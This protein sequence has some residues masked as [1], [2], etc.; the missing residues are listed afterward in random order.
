MPLHVNSGSPE[1]THRCGCFCLGPL[2][3]HGS[4]VGAHLSLGRGRT[5]AHRKECTFNNGLAFSSR[6]V[7]VGEEVSLQVK[8]R[9]GLWSGSLRLG[10]TNVPPGSRRLPPPP[11]AIPH[12]TD[13]AGHWAN[14]VPETFCYPGSVVTFW[15]SHGGTVYCRVRNCKRHK[16]VEAV[17]LS[18]PLWAMLDVYGQTC[19]VLLLGSEKKHVLW[20]RTSC[21]PPSSYGYKQPQHAGL[22]DSIQDLCTNDK[23]CVC[24]QRKKVSSGGQRHHAVWP[25]LPVPPV[26]CAGDPGNRNV[27]SLSP[28]NLKLQTRVPFISVTV[29]GLTLNVTNVMHILL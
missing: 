18:Q 16:L 12:L 13:T 22:D 11:M 14:I 15:V 28:S 7:R 24:Y 27:S 21:P 25:P 8:K 10:F 19:A 6:P 4:A 5:L 2:A 29:A 9:V 20:T 26:R 3:F 1:R 17:D 23:S